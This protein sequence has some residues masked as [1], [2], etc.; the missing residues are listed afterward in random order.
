MDIC[1]V[2][3]IKCNMDVV[4]VFWHK[5]I[6][7]NEPDKRLE[8]PCFIGYRW[9]NKTPRTQLAD[10]AGLGTWVPKNLT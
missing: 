2:Q 1:N 5:Y 7:D 4:S 10:D 3:N 9:I 6:W 8:Y